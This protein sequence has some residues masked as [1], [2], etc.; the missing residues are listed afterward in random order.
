MN[1]V[2]RDSDRWF[3]EQV[4]PHGPAV[5]A[6]LR[7]RFSTLSDA[8]DLVQEAY[9]RVLKAHAK[10]PIANPRAFLFTTARNLALNQ[11]RHLRYSQPNGLTETDL[12]TVLDGGAGIPET[13]VHAE[14]LQFLIAAIQSLPERCRQI[15]TLRKIYG[16]SQKEVAARLHIS[17]HTV[18][19]QGGIG[20]RKCVEYF[21][22]HNH[23]R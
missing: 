8:E 2:Q 4:L 16:L 15:I 13:I 17:E 6:W 7:A 23:A 22:K 9:V 5:L 20:L 3:A 19:A 14:E 18:E 10:G 21:R 11:L 1:P 12:S